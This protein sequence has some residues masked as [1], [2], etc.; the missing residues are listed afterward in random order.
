MSNRPQNGRQYGFVLRGFTLVELLVVIAIIGVLIGL[1]LPAVQAARE[2][3]RRSA[4]QNNLKQL[5]LGMVTYYS[6]MSSFP[7]GWKMTGSSGL[8]STNWAWGAFVL[9]YIEQQ[10][11]FNS[12]SPDST[13]ASGTKMGVQIADFKCP[14]LAPRTSING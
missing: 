6:S 4:C 2:S 7:S 11:A 13:T 1:L 8:G 12:L 14:T 10:A 5:G 3:A 9:P